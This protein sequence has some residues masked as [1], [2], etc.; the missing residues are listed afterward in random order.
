MVEG[1]RGYHMGHKVRVVSKISPMMLRLITKMS[2][3]RMQMQIKFTWHA[4]ST[5]RWSWI[6]FGYITQSNRSMR[7]RLGCLPWF[8]IQLLNSRRCMP[9]CVM[10]DV[11]Y[12]NVTVYGHVACA[13]VNST[14]LLCLC[15][16]KVHFELNA[17]TIECT[18]LWF[19]CILQSTYNFAI[20]TIFSR[21]CVFYN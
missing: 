13:P 2:L 17:F 12:W 14:I 5:E 6:M 18:V 7:A 11:S 19:M 9:Y 21:R 4:P 16:H 1:E 8:Q 20:P 15:K 3:S 10:L